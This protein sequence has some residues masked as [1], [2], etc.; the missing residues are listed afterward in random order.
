MLIPEAD[1]KILVEFL[2][3]PSEQQDSI[4]QKLNSISPTLSFKE[5]EEIITNEIKKDSQHFLEFIINLS[6]NFFYYQGTIEEFSEKVVIPSIIIEKSN[7]EIEE[8]DYGKARLIIERILN[9]EKTIGIISK[10]SYLSD[11][12]PN[13]YIKSHIISD[14]RYIFYSEP[15]KIPD[16][17]LIKHTFKID[18]FS[19]ME[20]QEIFLTV[21]IE[22]LQEIENNIKRAINKEKTLRELSNKNKTHILKEV[23]Y[24]I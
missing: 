11:E 17:A 4:F 24:D 12:N 22:D 23:N 20:M 6:M 1:L 14:L 21:S 8:K 9:L 3:F 15:T 13:H 10:I 7:I 18:Y 19:N 2:K 16:Y 5:L